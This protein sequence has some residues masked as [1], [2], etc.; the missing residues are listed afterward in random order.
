MHT[1]VR[2]GE[3]VELAPRPV[4][5]HRAVLHA[6]DADVCVVELTV[7]KGFYVRAYARDLAAQLGTVAHLTALRRLASG[8]FSLEEAVDAATLARAATGDTGA[9]NALVAKVLPLSSL[10]RAMPVLT[11]DDAT[12]RALS[13]GKR[14]PCACAGAA[15]LV[16]DGAGAPVCVGAT[17]DGFLRVARGFPWPPERASDIPL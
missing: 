15:V 12:A 3:S 8:P 7:S 4:V 5:I 16:L 2:R 13:Q 10:G 6:A 17:D 11:V 9:R 14:V 1:R